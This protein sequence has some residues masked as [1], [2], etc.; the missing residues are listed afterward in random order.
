[1]LFCY[2]KNK[3]PRS[4]KLHWYCSFSTCFRSY[5]VKYSKTILHIFLN[6]VNKWSASKVNDSKAYKNFKASKTFSQPT[7]KTGQAITHMP[8]K[9]IT[10]KT[11]GIVF[12][13][14][15]NISVEIHL[16][17][18]GWDD[19]N[20]G[21]RYACGNGSLPQ[22]AARAAALATLWPGTRTQTVGF[23]GS[24]ACPQQREAP[25][26]HCSQSLITFYIYHCS[27]WTVYAVFLLVGYLCRP[28]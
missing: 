9:A 24:Q 10:T 19:V 4:S 21:L 23:S 27:Y 16:N 1:M 12:Q 6:I 11:H 8:V 17:L 14:T 13:P 26:F 5:L 7:Q 15:S 22:W 20:T 2:V 3:T 28:I 18:K 25:S